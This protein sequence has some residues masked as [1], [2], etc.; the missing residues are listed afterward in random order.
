MLLSNNNVSKIVRITGIA[1]ALDF[2]LLSSSFPALAEKSKKK[3]NSVE[4]SYQGL[5]SNRRDGGSRGNCVANGKDFVALVPETPV[6]ATAS[7]SS[8]LFF[9]V[10]QT[11]KPKI[12]E[13]VLRNKDDKLVHEAFVQTTGEAGIM[14]VKIPD[15]IQDNLSQTLGDY[16]WYLSMICDPNQRSR[17][18]VLEGWIKYVELDNSVQQKIDLS[19]S[20]ETSNLLQQEGIWYDALTVLAEQKKL[21][22]NL[23]SLKTEWSQMLESIGLVEL[24]S[25]PLITTETIE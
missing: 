20:I 9:Y 25:E 1:L 10:P 13:F 6:N 22:S 15:Q 3:E 19:N 5:P 8:Q 14:S 2:L 16:H 4:L 21:G 18:I 7:I 24:S 12:I 17:D 11:E 23:V